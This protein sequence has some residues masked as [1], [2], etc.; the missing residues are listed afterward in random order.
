MTFALHFGIKNAQDFQS[1]FNKRRS[2]RMKRDGQSPIDL[3]DEQKNAMLG[4][5][6]VRHKKESPS[7]FSRRSLIRRLFAA[8][9]WAAGSATAGTTHQN[10]VLLSKPSPT[11]LHFEFQVS[12]ALW[13]H[14]VMRPQMSFTDFLKVHAALSEADFQK[15]LKKALRQM[16][17]ENFIKL[18]SGEKLS[19]IHWR[20]PET[21][22]L[23]TLLQKNLL[24][25]ELPPQI[26]AHLEPMVIS[27]S[28]QSKKNLSRIQLT[29]SPIF[30]PILAQ[31]QQDQVWF[32]PHIPAALIDL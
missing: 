13:L 15:A 7:M 19:L 14:Q 28:V 2:G 26:Q 5:C 23:Q 21:G 32:T 24:L 30:Y 11:Q 29:L 18:F 3:M 6:K 8:T 27:A 1:L 9:F 10:Q 22:T 20:L 17:I 25:L 4:C 31:Y 16:E 12:P